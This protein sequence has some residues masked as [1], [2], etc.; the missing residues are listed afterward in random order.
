MEMRIIK[1]K[2]MAKTNNI[3]KKSFLYS[4]F[5]ILFVYKIRLQIVPPY[6]IYFDNPAQNAAQ[7]MIMDEIKDIPII[8]CTAIPL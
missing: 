6:I 1:N 4:F 3:N 7:R 2:N 5:L 8:V